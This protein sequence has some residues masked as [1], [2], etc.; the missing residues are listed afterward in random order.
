ML[1]QD[2]NPNQQLRDGQ[3]TRLG[4]RFYTV[5]TYPKRSVREL[6]NTPKNRKLLGQLA[7]LW[8]LLP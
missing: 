5:R 2:R 1:H 6:S 3:F 7:L 8:L 4:D